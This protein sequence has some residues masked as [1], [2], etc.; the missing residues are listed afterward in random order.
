MD[1]AAVRIRQIKPAF[2]TDK[3]MA[4]LSKSARLTYIG[5][6][7]LSDDTGWIEWDIE[8]AGAELLPFESVKRRERDLAADLEALTVAGR[9]IPHDCGCLF[10]PH[11]EEHQRISGVRS[12]RARDAHAKHQPRSATQVP[13]SDSPGK[14]GNGKE[15]NVEVARDDALRDDRT[16][17]EKVPLAAEVAERLGMAV[18]K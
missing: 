1:S 6:W 2:W 18:A 12:V 17:R 4:G 5:L 11:L 8:Q 13:L 7:M 16:L 10:V 3:V 9:V 14:V 15:R